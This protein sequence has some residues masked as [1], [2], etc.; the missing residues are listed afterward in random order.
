MLVLRDSFS[1]QTQASSKSHPRGVERE[2]E[3][4]VLF[5]RPTR[6]SRNSALAME[7]VYRAW[8]TRL[9]RTAG[10]QN[11]IRNNHTPLGSKLATVL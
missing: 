7:E 8:D 4:R 2:G 1:G 5:R 10:N 11:H 6:S 3:A 9:V